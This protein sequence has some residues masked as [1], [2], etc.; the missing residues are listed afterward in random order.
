VLRSSRSI[1]DKPHAFWSD[2]TLIPALGRQGHAICVCI[3]DDIDCVGHVLFAAGQRLLYPAIRTSISILISVSISKRATG[4][5]SKRLC[6][7]AINTQSLPM[8]V[9]VGLT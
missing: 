4:S 5:G 2:M 7:T 3:L 6:N 9:P 1:N 8:Y